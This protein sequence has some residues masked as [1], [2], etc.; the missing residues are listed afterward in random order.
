LK[1]YRKTVQAKGLLQG[2]SPH[3]AAQIRP[4]ASLSV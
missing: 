4:A 3:R 2:H 1:P